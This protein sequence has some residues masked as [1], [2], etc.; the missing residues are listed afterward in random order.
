MNSR[1]K[2][3]RGERDGAAAWADAL[4]LDPASCRRGQQFAG[5]TDSPDVVHPLGDTVHLEVKR[6]ERGNPY[7]WMQQAEWDAGAKI[8]VVLHRRNNKPW[9]AIV[10]LSDV[11]RLS[12]E[13]A[14]KTEALGGREV[15]GPVPGQGV[16]QAEGQNE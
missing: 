10:R 2:G 3:A 1:Q 6:V 7:L 4:K 11:A 12:Q 9:L 5:G 8:P 15:P 13:I 16:S 14:Q